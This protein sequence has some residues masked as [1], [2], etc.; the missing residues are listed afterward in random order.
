MAN[1]DSVA[2]LRCRPVQFFRR[3]RFTC[4]A[5][6]Q[7]KKT[8]FPFRRARQMNRSR[9]YTVE[10]KK[11]SVQG[12]QESLRRRSTPS[13]KVNRTVKCTQASEHSELVYMRANRRAVKTIIGRKESNHTVSLFFLSAWLSA[14]DR[15]VLIERLWLKTK[16]KRS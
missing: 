16:G 14:A 2:W 5:R 4:R 15:K 6:Q 9:R 7:R 8:F 3:L 13:E 11:E 1:W 10:R 12:L